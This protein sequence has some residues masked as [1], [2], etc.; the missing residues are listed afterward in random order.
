MR[1]TH[2]HI[3]LYNT[4]VVLY[5]FIVVQLLCGSVFVTSRTGDSSQRNSSE[6]EDGESEKSY[7]EEE[8]PHREAMECVKDQ[9]AQI[10]IVR[11]AIRLLVCRVRNGYNNHY[12]S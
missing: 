8:M 7:E 10:I 4:L 11:P 6:D 5:L 12:A 1:C 9:V 3:H 2:N